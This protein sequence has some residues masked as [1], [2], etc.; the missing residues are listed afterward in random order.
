M[1]TKDKRNESRVVD[2]LTKYKVIHNKNNF[3]II[4]FFPLT[5][6]THQIRIVQNT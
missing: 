4:L 2:S 1:M 3:S 5:G 6:K